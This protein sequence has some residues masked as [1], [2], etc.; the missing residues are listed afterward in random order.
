MNLQDPDLFR[1]AALIDG[2]WIARPELEVTD[3]A[4]GASLG[5]LPDCT[6][7][8]TREA[9]AA[10]AQ[11]MTGWAARTH[12]DRAD[13]LMRWYQLIHDHAEDLAQILTAEQGKPLSE[14][15][16]EVGYGAS[17]VRWFAEEARRINGKIIPRR[18]RARKS[19]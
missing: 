11:A 1:I 4:T 15:R 17:F 10:A 2:H 19:S 7:A 16:A 8:E 14:A 3:P 6:A 13:I 9:I 18:R 12:A 5:R